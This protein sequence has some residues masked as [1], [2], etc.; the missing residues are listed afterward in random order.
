MKNY[1]DRKKIVSFSDYRE[2]FGRGRRR[3][4]KEDEGERLE[5]LTVV[6]DLR[7]EIFG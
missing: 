4:G 2:Q 3:W 7:R 1:R 6:R 5:G